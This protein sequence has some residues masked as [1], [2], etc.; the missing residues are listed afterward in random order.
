M[1]G[2]GVRSLWA[3][4][5]GGAGI[6]IY[7][8]IYKQTE[9]WRVYSVVES[10]DCFCRGARFNSQ[11]PEGS[12]QLAICNPSSSEYDAFLSPPQEPDTH[13]MHIHT[14][15]QANTHTPKIIKIKKS[16]KENKS[17]LSNLCKASQ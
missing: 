1:I 12:S 5:P 6:H 9:S 7:I 13:V 10:T 17:K 14:Y 11:L 8:H 2:R 4:G 16:K 15:I 3:D